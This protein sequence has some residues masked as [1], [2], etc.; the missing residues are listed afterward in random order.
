MTH[1]FK[2]SPHASFILPI[3]G[4][5]LIDNFPFF[6]IIIHLRKESEQVL[7]NGETLFHVLD[8]RAKRKKL[9]AGRHVSLHHTA[10]SE[11]G[12]PCHVEN[13]F[14]TRMPYAY[15]HNWWHPQP[16]GFPFVPYPLP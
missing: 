15:L 10:G 1:F 5:L 3:F 9:R 11:S 12:H 4:R 2:L 6:I 13:T 8:S 14:A 7:E 16:Q